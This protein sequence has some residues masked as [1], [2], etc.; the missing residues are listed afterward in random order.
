MNTIIY[1]GKEI[2]VC[3]CDDKLCEK[4]CVRKDPSLKYRDDLSTAGD[5]GHYLPQDLV[6][7]P[8]SINKEVK[9]K[10][11]KNNNRISTGIRCLAIEI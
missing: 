10:Y 11:G 1:Q 3:G 4:Q 5:C 2:T 7:R 9:P 6:G 8:D